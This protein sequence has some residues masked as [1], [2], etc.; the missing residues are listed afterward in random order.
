MNIAMITTL[1]CVCFLGLII[2]H[3]IIEQRREMGH[4]NQSKKLKQRQQLKSNVVKSYPSNSKKKENQV[5]IG[6]NQHQK[7]ID[8]NEK[9]KE[10]NA[11]MNRTNKKRL[12]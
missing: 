7:V 11:E 8:L 10:R 4:Q 5:K 9:R 6:I 12:P 2:A 3:I 1:G